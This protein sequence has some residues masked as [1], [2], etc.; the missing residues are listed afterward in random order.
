MA[1]E[2]E[3]TFEDSVTSDYAQAVTTARI[4]TYDDFRSAPRVT[5]ISPCRTNEYIE[6]L[7]STIYTQAQQAG[8]TIPYTVIR[9]VSENFIHAQFKEIVVSIFDRGNTIR[10]ADQGP[11]IEEKEKA[12][13][14]G[15]SSATSPMKRY[16]RGV[17]SGLPL[18][19]EYLSF[20]HGRISIEDN[21]HSGAV[22][23]VSVAPDHEP[24]HSASSYPTQR[25]PE[26]T[27]PIPA[28]RLDDR[29]ASIA[30]LIHENG[31]MR[32]T[33]IYKTLDMPQSSTYRVLSK[34]KEAGIVDKN[35]K[36]FT[37]TD[38]GKRSLESIS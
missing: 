9:E 21:M 22:V 30:L 7:A 31:A 8:G 28:I 14:P 26:A 34:M 5:E 2:M 20:S 16:I 10:F 12:Q 33:D 13:L 38:E 15:F 36:M 4:A 17:G 25:N 1:Y 23:T 11:G 27:P 32:L 37:L 24:I 6:N 19:K 35:G 29:E 18:V 3:N